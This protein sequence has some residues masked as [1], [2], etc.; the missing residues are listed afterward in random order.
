MPLARVMARWLTP[1]PPPWDRLLPRLPS[2]TPQGLANTAWGLAR[3]EHEAPEAF[4]AIAEEAPDL[5]RPPPASP[6]RPPSSLP[7]CPGL[8]QVL[9]QLPKEEGGFSARE[10]TALAW[11]FRW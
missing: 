11:S 10:L 6:K 5:P 1:P 8:P 3:A 9:A 2:F 7:I 4:D